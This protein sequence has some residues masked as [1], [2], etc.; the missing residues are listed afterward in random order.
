M[1][2]IGTISKLKKTARGKLPQRVLD[3]FEI[4]LA[5]G[6]IAKVQESPFTILYPTPLR[7]SYLIKENDSKRNYLG[8]EA[9]KWNKHID[10]T[11]ST[12]SGVKRFF[13]PVYLRHVVNS[14]L[15]GEYREAV[16]VVKPPVQLIGDSRYRRMMR[17]FVASAD[18][19]ERLKE[20]RTSPLGRRRD[21]LSE[22]AEKL[23]AFKKKTMGA[24]VSR[25]RGE[26]AIFEKR[27]QALQVI[28]DFLAK[29]S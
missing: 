6:G 8:G 11:S 18:Y 23:M 15:S 25:I 9:R 4:Y 13:D 17:M 27:A 29:Y 19:R 5:A 1:K 3:A 10:E 21:S 12:R 14:A 24:R 7:L 2:V 22:S 16:R 20:A 26:L 28:R